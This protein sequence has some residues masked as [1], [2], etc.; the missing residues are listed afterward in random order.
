MFRKPRDWDQ[1]KIHQLSYTRRLSAQGTGL[2]RKP[3]NCLVVTK[4][5]FACTKQFIHS[6]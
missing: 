3:V 6:L 1:G 2:G 4:Q 5:D